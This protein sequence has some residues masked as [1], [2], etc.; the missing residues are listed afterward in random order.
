M[1]RDCQANQDP[2]ESQ[3]TKVCQDYQDYRDPKETK[4]WAS[5]D[6]LVTKGFQGPQDLLAQ[7]G[8]LVLENLG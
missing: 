1:D 2:K 6:N 4:E 3:V 5:Q 7:E 8:C